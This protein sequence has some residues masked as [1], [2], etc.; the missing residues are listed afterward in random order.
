MANLNWY[1]HN[2]KKIDEYI[3]RTDY[4]EKIK[5]ITLEEPPD[6]SGGFNV[7]NIERYYPQIDMK[8]EYG[9]NTTIGG[10]TKQRT[11]TEL[12]FNDS[13]EVKV[14]LINFS[15]YQEE[16]D[17]KYFYK[18]T[19]PFYE[20]TY[21]SDGDFYKWE[22]NKYKYLFEGFYPN[23]KDSEIPIEDIN[24]KK[25]IDINVG[26]AL[27]IIINSELPVDI[28]YIDKIY[29]NGDKIEP[30]TKEEIQ[31]S[32]SYTM[33]DGLRVELFGLR[34]THKEI[35]PLGEIE[36][37]EEILIHRA[38]I[39]LEDRLLPPGR[40]DFPTNFW[41]TR[42]ISKLPNVFNYFSRINKGIKWR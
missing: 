36:E 15:T 31:V 26:K 19:F 28:K 9:S 39:K 8:W 20:Y 35:H 11:Y 32:W 33:L 34:M 13:D 21:S 30:L 7:A 1:E 14:E 22:V 40:K 25:S 4:K 23:E 2:P 10:K 37:E 16:L 17:G 5:D 6:L 29:R 12:E 41:N 3:K 42:D 38:E 18:L 24:N 27:G